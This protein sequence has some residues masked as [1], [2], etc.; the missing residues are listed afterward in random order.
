MA[1]THAAGEEA[2]D[3]HE[4]LGPAV[5]LGSRLVGGAEAQEDGVARLHAD[6]GRPRIVRDRV[7]Q[8]GDEA[9]DEQQD[10]D[11]GCGDGLRE[12]GARAL[13]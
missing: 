13:P 11:V 12:V 5:G 9:A 8:A 1:E 6:E 3:A 2:A 7:D 10:G 4:A